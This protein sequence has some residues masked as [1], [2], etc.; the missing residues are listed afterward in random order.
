M[1]KRFY[2][3]FS[4]SIISALTSFGTT[5]SLAQSANELILEEIVVT[6]RKRGELLQEVPLSVSVFTARQIQDARIDHVEDFI[7][8]TPNMS[9]VVVA[10][11]GT[12]FTTIRGIT[13]VR[14]N[15]PPM[16]TIVDGVQ[17]SNRIQFTQELFDLESIEVVR[18]P[19]GT[20]YGRN[21]IGGAIIIKT[22]QPTNEF[23]RNIQLSYGRDEDYRVQGS[24]SGP[25]IE[26]KLLFRIAAKYQNRDGYF[27]NR[28]LGKEVDSFE[29]LTIRGL[30]KTQLNDQL[31]A[32]IHANIVRSD[33]G[34]TNFRWQAAN[35]TP[36]GLAWDGTFDF[37]RLDANLVDRDYNQRVLCDSNR[38]IDEIAL[39][40]D[41]DVGWGTITSISS[42]ARIEEYEGGEQAPYT[43]LTSLFG[44]D[45]FQTQYIDIDTWSEEIRLT[46]NQDQRI[47]WLAG[48]YFLSTDRFISTTV[49]T[50]MG[51]PLVRLE[52]DPFFD[53]PGN[54]TTSWNA[55]DNDNFAWAVFFNADYEITDN[56]VLSA[57]IRYDE[58][59]R[60]Q[61]VDTR[62]TVGIPG[63]V[64]KETA[65]EVQPKVSLNYTFNDDISAYFSWGRGFRSG[66][67]NQNGL[68]VVA[69]S[70]G[71]NGVELFA[72]SEVAE[73]FEAGF[74]SELLNNRLRL[75]GSV[76]YTEDENA[77]YFVFLAGIGAQVLVP[78]NEVEMVGGEVEILARIT[79]NI[80]MYAA[81]GVL[82]SEIKEY[83]VDPNQVGNEAPYIPEI[84]FN[85]G[86]QYRTDVN[87]W[88]G[89]FA[90]IDY[91]HRGEQ[92]WTTENLFPRES[93]DLVH[94][95][96]GF[97]GA[98][99]SWSLIASINNITDLV[100]NAEWVGGGF[101]H[102][103]PP[104]T[105]A[106]DLSYRF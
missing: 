27:K 101:S 29:D 74:K 88:L 26:D 91:E 15:E 32:D 102:P 58:D 39:K 103:A 13:S 89:I 46:S 72:P 54:P 33:A 87:D 63:I 49:S 2:L 77:P 17:Q 96:L 51:S 24:F 98:D 16:A 73:T 84:T 66:Q 18:G 25:I 14:N 42:Y 40:I 11:P 93:L 68:D 97:E 12:S 35:L 10:S 61:T 70:I 60:E 45:G 1:N 8:M 79:E 20:L 92:F 85:I 21:A 31:S 75:N 23:R 44:L 95:R 34:C 67:F 6:A 71:L 41:Y 5:S 36:D 37:T 99:D 56:L 94:V 55:D 82:D 22:Q 57:G 59:E 86:A 4:I 90:R 52:R 50:D 47:R 65:S 30:L 53:D 78:I 76:F 38:D 105:W 48:A 43:T 7:G 62:N 28:Y 80:D 19:Q 9:T 106:V 81:V 69:A 83:A 64:N 104:L 3:I 100:Y